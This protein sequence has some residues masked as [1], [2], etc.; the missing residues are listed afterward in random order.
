[1]SVVRYNAKSNNMTEER[2]F[3]TWRKCS[4]CRVAKKALDSLG[5]EVEE[6]DFFENAMNRD[7]LLDLVAAAGID[8]LFSWRSP[9]AK[10]YRERRDTITQDELIEAMLS[11]P[12]LIRRPIVVSANLP[13]VIGF[14][15]D[16]Y[17]SLKG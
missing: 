7:E 2:R 9:S 13:P 15:A 5:V 10:P 12:R 14:N 17:A 6:R 1:M 16:A 11:E 3:Y 4:T 8:N